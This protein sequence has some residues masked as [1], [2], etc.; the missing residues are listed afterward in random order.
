MG[1]LLESMAGGV[2]AH[3][4]DEETEALA[5]MTKHLFAAFPTHLSPPL[6]ELF[7]KPS[8]GSPPQGLCTCYGLHLDTLCPSF[9]LL[10]SHLNLRAQLRSCHLQEAFPENSSV[11]FRS[12]TSLGDTHLSCYVRF[13]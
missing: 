13:I 3:D 4:A 12:Q 10:N 1:S 7:F 6:T 2:S 8:S 9:Y 11:S 5:D